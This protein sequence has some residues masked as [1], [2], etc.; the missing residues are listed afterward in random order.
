M[1]LL[2]VATFPSVSYKRHCTTLDTGCTYDRLGR[3]EIPAKGNITESTQRIFFT[4][5]LICKIDAF[6]LKA[7]FPSCK[8]IELPPPVLLES[9]SHSSG[10]VQTDNICKEYLS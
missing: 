3:A 1:C 10:M 4:H 2:L 9:L 5:P 6:I 7:A 8:T